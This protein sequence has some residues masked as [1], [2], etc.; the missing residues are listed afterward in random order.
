M[1]DRIK[2]RLYVV[3]VFLIHPIYIPIIWLHVGYKNE[4][5]IDYKEMFKV[6]KLGRR[7]SGG[8]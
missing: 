2:F 7:L 4:G 5:W 1:W 6:F 3:L 8:E